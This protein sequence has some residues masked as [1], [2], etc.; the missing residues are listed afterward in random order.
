MKLAVDEE[1]N[2]LNLRKWESH[3][4]GTKRGHPFQVVGIGKEEGLKCNSLPL[5]KSGKKPDP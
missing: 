2:I 5:K 3:W 4:P 1:E